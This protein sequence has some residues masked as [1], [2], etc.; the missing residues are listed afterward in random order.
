MEKQANYL[1]S[2]NKLQNQLHLHLLQMTTQSI[3]STSTSRRRSLPK[4]KASP[5][6]PRELE[7]S[8]LLTWTNA[9]WFGFCNL[10]FSF[11][12]HI[13]LWD[14]LVAIAL[15]ASYL[16]LLL[17][18]SLFKYAFLLFGHY[19]RSKWKV[20]HISKQNL[21]VLLFVFL[22]LQLPCV[23][24]SPTQSYMNFPD[25]TWN[26]FNS[27]VHSYFDSDVKL[28]TVLIT[29]CSILENPKFFSLHSWAQLGLQSNEIPRELITWIKLFTNLLLD[30]LDS[31]QQQLFTRK[32]RQTLFDQSNSANSANLQSTKANKLAS[33]INTL[34]KLLDFASYNSDGTFNKQF[35]PLDSQAL[36]PLIIACPKGM[37]CVTSIC[38]P[39][40]LH[41]TTCFWDVPRVSVLKG[42]KVYSSGA[43]INGECTR[44]QVKYA[45]DH[46]GIPYQAAK[47]QCYLNTARYI[48]IG[49]NLWADRIFAQSILN[50]IYSFHAS[51]DAITGWWNLSFGAQ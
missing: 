8:K 38:N 32:E 46:E 40:A 17:F 27:F 4:A 13:Y 49:A 2:R 10:S 37:Y 41:T 28:G 39:Y 45:A 21:F 12:F 5:K 30:H 16:C 1:V 19:L 29:L 22:G 43:V 47:Y 50:A 36:D 20:V 11:V 6:L 23:L 18:F 7:R 33:K 25:V 15:S 35:L 9:F 42:S 26:A 24:A 34:T 3:T 31:A 51:A 48:K 14:I 44:C